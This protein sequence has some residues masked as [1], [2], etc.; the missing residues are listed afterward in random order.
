MSKP[1]IYIDGQA[2]TTGLEIMTRLKERDDIELLIIDDK[3]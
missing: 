3:D 2:G 1:K